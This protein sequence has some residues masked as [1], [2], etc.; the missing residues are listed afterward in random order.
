MSLYT[1]LRLI[2]SLYELV[3]S[4]YILIEIPLKISFVYF[5]PTPTV[6]DLGIIDFVVEDLDDYGEV[7]SRIMHQ[8]DGTYGDHLSQSS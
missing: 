1:S 6:S 2:F 5:I 7:H 8:R 3:N 4:C